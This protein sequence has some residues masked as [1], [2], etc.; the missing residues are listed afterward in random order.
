MAANA[1][2]DR[3]RASADGVKPRQAIAIPLNQNWDRRADRDI[4]VRPRVPV[5]AFAREP[6]HKNKFQG[7]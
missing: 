5:A 3:A 1:V 6:K 2:H 7:E 4:A